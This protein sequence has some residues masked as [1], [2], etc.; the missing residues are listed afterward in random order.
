MM[1]LP[2][3]VMALSVLEREYRETVLV[4]VRQT[5]RSQL[6]P[7][8]HFFHAVQIL[9]AAGMWTK[10]PGS[11]K[12]SCGG[13]VSSLYEREVQRRCSGDRVPKWCV[14]GGSAWISEQSHT[15]S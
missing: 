1:R 4:F 12:V 7:S 11:P 13:N 5:I 6:L 14:Q 2:S 10:K 3:C 8:D 9:D 15:L